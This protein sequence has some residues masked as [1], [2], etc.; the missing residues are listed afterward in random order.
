M[1]QSKRWIPIIALAICAVLALLGTLT[2]LPPSHAG[3][4]PFVFVTVV[5]IAAT[6]VTILILKHGDTPI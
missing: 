4:N 1:E 6:M 5:M 3:I 2:P